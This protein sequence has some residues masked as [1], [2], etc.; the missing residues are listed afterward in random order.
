M[1]QSGDS[2]IIESETAPTED[3]GEYSTAL[4]NVTD[5]LGPRQVALHCPLGIGTPAERDR[6]RVHVFR[7][8]SLAEN[9]IFQVYCTQRDQRVGWCLP[10]AALGSTEHSHADNEHFLPYVRGATRRILDPSTPILV[11][12]VPDL[13]DRDTSLVSSCFSDNCV[14]IILSCDV[15][16][17]QDEELSH[18]L[19][20]LHAHGYAPATPNNLLTVDFGEKPS[21]IR[22]NLDCISDDL[23]DHAFVRALFTDLIPAEPNAILRFFYYY[24]LVEILMEMVLTSSHESLAQ[25]LVNAKGD[26][27]QIKG[28]LKRFSQLAS[29][30]NVL[31]DLATKHLQNVDDLSHLRT[32]CNDLAISCGRRKESTWWRALYQVRNIVFHNYREIND[33]LLI[34]QV[35]R[36]LTQAIPSLTSGFSKDATSNPPEDG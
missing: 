32:A 28:L 22:L 8:H 11:P 25:E 14:L 13:D 20:A 6:Y 18:W 9:N 12:D 16:E 36:A 10:I 21:G 34:E 1:L 30:T 26:Y 7:H 5:R 27:L 35:V 3:R 19:P 17:E 15:I 2:E 23:A 24:Q 33:T 4:C 31:A 29:E